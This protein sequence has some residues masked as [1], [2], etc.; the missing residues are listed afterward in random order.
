MTLRKHMRKIHWRLG[1]WTWNL[2]NRIHCFR[3]GHPKYAMWDIN[4][5]FLNNIS[6]VLAEIIEHTNGCPTQL[7]GLYTS[8]EMN[9]DFDRCHKIWINTLRDMKFGFDH[10]IHVCEKMEGF[11]ELQ[12]DIRTID[13]FW[14]EWNRRDASANRSLD[15]SLMLFSKYFRHLWD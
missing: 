10:Y 14:M 12:K 6:K 3:H 1:D 2:E 7:D 15:R 4:G 9:A 13:E 8:E 5:W 11:D